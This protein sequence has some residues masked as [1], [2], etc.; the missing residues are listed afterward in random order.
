MK[1]LK[2]KAIIAAIAAAIVTTTS[3]VSASATSVQING[4]YCSYYSNKSTTTGSST[5]G[6]SADP[7]SNNLWATV[8]GKVKYT[9]TQTGNSEE[10][11]MAL[12]SGT[13][14]AT[15]S[16][17]VQ[18]VYVMNWVHGTHTFSVNGDQGDG[19][20]DSWA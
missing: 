7:Y 12:A 2:S 5:S 17:S 1:K 20:Y 9:H 4:V 11:D 13:P 3:A 8:Y 19:E 10:R 15:T 18:S 16:K 6:I 14:G